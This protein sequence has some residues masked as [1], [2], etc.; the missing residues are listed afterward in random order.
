MNRSASGVASRAG[1][2]AI[3]LLAV[4]TASA[5]IVVAVDS[6]GGPAGA[7]SPSANRTISVSGD[8]TVQGVPDTLVATYRVHDKASDVQAALDAA[9]TDVHRVIAVLGQQGVA[10]RDIQ[11]TDLSLDTSYDSHGQPDGYEASETLAVRIHPLNKVG[12]IISAAATSAGNAVSIDGLS[13]DITDDAALL[14]AARGKAFAAA[15]AAASRDA[16]LAGEHLGQVLTVKES[17]TSP[18]VPQPYYA[19]SD[20]LGGSAKSI[21]IRPGQQ[22][23]TVT[24][25][26]VWTLQ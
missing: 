14:D 2:I 22:P 7:S 26:G 1:V 5:A 15:R 23:V 4:L 16:A 11:T 10:R 12:R 3:A 18:S 9:A 20:A 21:A 25:A 19:R 24:L 6:G 8:G 17:T 13:L